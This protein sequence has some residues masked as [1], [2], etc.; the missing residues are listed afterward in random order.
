MHTDLKPQLRELQITGAK[1]VD[2]AG[3][4]AVVVYVPYPQ[5]KP[6]HK[7]QGRLIRELEKK[8]S[9]KHVVFVAKRTILAKPTRKIRTKSKQKRRRS[10]TLTSVYDSI[11][12]DLVYPAEIVGKR[13]RVRLGGSRLI[14]VHLDKASQTQIE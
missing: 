12:E 7:I 9:G 1:E 5:L 11:L 6:F 3:K 10:R 13:T 4:K 14:K 2:V 8:F